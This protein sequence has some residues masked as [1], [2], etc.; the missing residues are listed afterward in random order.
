MKIITTASDPSQA[1]A[2]L[3]AGVDALIIG[4]ER[5]GLRLGGYFT[6]DE[7]KATIAA[8]KQA[9]KQVFIAMN[10]ILHNDKIATARPF[11]KKI[12]ALQPTGLVVGDTG[13]I[14]ILKEEEY[15]LPYLYDASVL[16]TSPGQV[17]FWAQYGAIGAIVAR[18]VPLEELTDMAQVAKIPLAVQVYGA[19]CIHQSA[20]PLLTK[21]FKEVGKDPA[22]LAEH[23]LFL[24]EPKAKETHYSIFEDEHGTHIFANNDLNLIMYVQKL[25]DLGIGYWYLDGLYTPGQPFVAI[26]QRFVQA[27]DEILGDS[28]QDA[29]ALKLDEEI[30]QLH[31][32][33]RELSTGFFLYD[34]DDVQ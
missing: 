14:Q 7:M 20:R 17:N 23:E 30:H 12:K 29:K 27:R 6:L 26:A 16:V 2:L 10:A 13:L 3:D 8:A 1:Q 28:W 32:K 33:N 9:G 4:E 24:S 22:E 15:Q 31:P 5:Y 18:E 21:Y 19:S 25:A 34:R 11:L